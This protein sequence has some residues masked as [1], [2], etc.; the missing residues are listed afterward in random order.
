MWARPG[1]AQRG[2]QAEQLARRYLERQGLRFEQ[3]NFRCR[4]GEIDLIM[5]DGDSLVFVE[6]RYRRNDRYGSAAETVDRQ[7]QRKLV[8]TAL[9]YLQNNPKQARL[10]SR[11]DVV[12][13]S[14]EGNAPRID[15]HPD[16][17]QIQD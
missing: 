5:R 4:R 7:K 2:N 11:F 1:G 6:V 10:T 3:A 15:W 8:T 17:I 13:I 12:A 9:F 14:G 16:A